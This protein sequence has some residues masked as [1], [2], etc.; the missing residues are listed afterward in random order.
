MSPNNLLSGEILYLQ[1]QLILPVESCLHYFKVAIF[2]LHLIFEIMQ[3]SLNYVSLGTPKQQSQ[4]LAGLARMLILFI[5]SISILFL[6]SPNKVK[7]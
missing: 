3:L 4:L 7:S 2:V 5:V 6:V 1:L